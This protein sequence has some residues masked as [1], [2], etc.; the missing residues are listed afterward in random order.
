MLETEIPDKFF[1]SEN[2]L[3]RTSENFNEETISALR[4]ARLISE[5]KIQSKS[6][7]T[8]DDLMRDL[9]SDADD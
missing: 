3:T 2:F 4:E 6:F 5:G 1:Q 9:I 7:K 8:V